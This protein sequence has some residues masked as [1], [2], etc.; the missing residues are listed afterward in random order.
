[1]AYLVVESGADK[2]KVFALAADKE[3]I[4][5]RGSHTD[6]LIRDPFVSAKHFAL[7]CVDDAWQ[8]N[9]LSSANGFEIN[10]KKVTTA[11]L[12]DNDL[13]RLGSTYLRFSLPLNGDE[14]TVS[15]PVLP[16]IDGYQLIDQLGV[17]GM[18]EVYQATQTS[19]DRPVA[20]KILFKKLRQDEKFVARFFQEARSAGNLNHP[21]IVQVHDVGRDGDL[22][23]ICME[24]IK[25]GTLTDL[26]RQSET[27]DEKTAMRIGLEVARG[28]A[29][30]QSKNL[31]HCDIK[32]D[33]IMFTETG[34][35][36]IADLGIAR[37]ASETPEA[38]NE[39]VGSPHYMSPEQAMGKA[40][41][42]RSDLYSLGCTL[43]RMLAGRTVFAGASAREVMK[44]QV[45][46]EPPP[47][48]KINPNI[49]SRM[50]GIVNKL[51]AKKPE[52]R[53]QSANELITAL[54]SITAVK[55]KKKVM[56][57]KM[58]DETSE[59]IAAEDGEIAFSWAA[60]LR[61]IIARVKK[62]DKTKLIAVPA[63]VVLV[64]II[65]WF[66]YFSVADQE[67]RF[68]Y[69]HAK[70]L[71]ERKNP[72][73]ALKELTNAPLAKDKKLAAEMTALRK[74]LEKERAKPTP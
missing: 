56:P 31:V 32:P 13:I 19:L 4:G 30:A 57:I 62:I 40:L 53:F 29:Y 73:Q 68:A 70:E 28:L 65:S 37:Q 52:N 39:V 7:K 45:T 58:V 51:I 20:I 55:T 9:D 35:A 5:G 24:Y 3:L 41:D 27:L 12:N 42:H 18:G 48:N 21:N 49:S 44:K 26:L 33:N 16:K 74:K 67:A 11:T 46:E 71:I 72:E 54:E 69:E 63:G 36:K 60:Y 22:C 61:G 17:G 64:I 34:M 50:L 6:I 10:E 59:A 43:F 14:N 2:R 23:Y 15:I 47:L 66:I 8:I 25:G 38:Q 1:M